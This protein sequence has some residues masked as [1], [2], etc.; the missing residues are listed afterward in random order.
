MIFRKS[1]LARVDV[2][3]EGM[4]C[5]RCA[6]KVEGWLNLLD[7][8]S[9][10]VSYK[11]G[12]ASLLCRREVSEEEIRGAVEQNGVYRVREIVRK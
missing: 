8:V 10:E 9:A 12:K 5:A 1:G 6:E 4:C 2:A 7:G 11:R 3:I